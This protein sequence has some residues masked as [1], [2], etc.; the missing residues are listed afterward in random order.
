MNRALDDIAPAFRAA[1][2]R[3]PNASNLR[4][5]YGDLARSYEEDGSSL[6]ELIKSFLEAVCWTVIN[7]L[8]ATPP[9]SSTPTTTELLSCVLDALGLRNQ[10]GV[11]PL[12]KVIS[13]HNKLAEGLNELRN[14]NGSVAHGRDGEARGGGLGKAF[15]GPFPGEGVSQTSYA[16][17]R[18]RGVGLREDPIPHGVAGTSY[19]R[20]EQL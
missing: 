16:F 4:Q 13:G 5:H 18:H 8:G 6:I 12:G 3:W 19:P 1:C 20:R 14:Q 15:A 7:E 11:G 2:D 17:R 10:R 9:D